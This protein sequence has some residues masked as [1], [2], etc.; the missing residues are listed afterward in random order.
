[1][2][3]FLKAQLTVTNLLFLLAFAA[4]LPAYAFVLTTREYDLPLIPGVMAYGGAAFALI[5]VRRMF[6]GQ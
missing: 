1:M 5:G 6:R 3:T 4:M 2:K